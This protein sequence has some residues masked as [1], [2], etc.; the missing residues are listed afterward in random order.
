MD[1]YKTILPL[2]LQKYYNPI[3]ETILVIPYGKH[4]T[5]ENL[6]EMPVQTVLEKGFTLH[7]QGY[8]MM[9]KPANADV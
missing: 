2:E 8:V 4:I 5:K 7:E 9:D 6:I 3:N 1:S